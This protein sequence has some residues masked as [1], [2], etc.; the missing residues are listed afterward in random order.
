MNR[1]YFAF[2]MLATMLASCSKI[3]KPAPAFSF[4]TLSNDVYDSE[5]LQNK[6][7]V[8]NVWATWCPTCIK[9]IPEL[10]RLQAKY[11]SDSSVV[12]IAL[13]DEPAEKMQPILDRFPFS[14]KQ[15]A[16]AET[17]T[18]KLQTRLVKTYPQNI[19][20]DH[21]F[22]IVFEVSDGS[23]DIYTALD[24]KLQEVLKPQI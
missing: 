14:Y 9:E 16:N 17:Y 22:D 2:I 20:I 24:T 1:L 3:G 13:C 18:K 11:A 12:F 4:T 8:V 19:I 21:N 7:I 5:S 6:I 10:N 15:V 23:D